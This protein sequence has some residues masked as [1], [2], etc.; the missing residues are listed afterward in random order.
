MEIE[1]LEILKQKLKALGITYNSIAF[2]ASV[3][4]DAVWCALNGQT[5]NNTKQVIT[6][7]LALIEAEKKAEEIFREQL[8]TSLN[9]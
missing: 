3:T 1:D 8:K 5:T 6:S 4:K 9:D 7:A 2:H